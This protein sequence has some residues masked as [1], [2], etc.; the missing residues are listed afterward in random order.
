VF[1]AEAGPA[2]AP[3]ALRAANEEWLG[4]HLGRDFQAWIAE[5]DGVPVASAGLL[6][7]SHPPGTTNPGG[8]E[9][10]ILNVY[11]RPEARRRGLARALMER[12]VDAARAAGV[13]RV[14]LRASV[15][16][17]PLYEAMGFRENN[18]LEL[19]PD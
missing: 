1:G 17:R 18:Y 9:A 13:R 15:E 7:F 19:I 4:E 6:W 12:A 2:D 3:G 14:W 8:L 16:G 5:L 10:Y 11:T